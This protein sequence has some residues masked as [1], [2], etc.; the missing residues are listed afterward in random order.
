MPLYPPPSSGSGIPA[1]TVTTKGDLI[2]ATG[3]A[4]V[5]RQGVGADGTVLV[6]NSG[7][8][9]GVNWRALTAADVAAGT[10]P[11]VMVFTSNAQF[12]RAGANLDL[13]KFTNSTANK[14]LTVRTGTTDGIEFVNN[15]YTA[16]INT[17]ADSG[18]LGIVAS[19]VP[20]TFGSGAA[21]APYIQRGSGLEVRS[22]GVGSVTDLT[23]DTFYFNDNTRNFPMATFATTGLTFYAGNNYT[24]ILEV[25]TT[26]NEYGVFIRPADSP[27]TVPLIIRG[28]TS[29]AT[30]LFRI[31]NPG[32]TATL[33]AI[34]QDGDTTIGANLYLGTGGARVWS[35]N[36][37]GT[38]RLYAGASNSMILSSADIQIATN[39]IIWSNP[40]INALAPSGYIIDFTAAQLIDHSS[41]F[42]YRVRQKVDGT[43]LQETFS[44][45]PT[46]GVKVTQVSNANL[47]TYDIGVLVKAAA[48]QNTSTFEGQNSSGTPTFQVTPAGLVTAA[49]G[50]TSTANGTTTGFGYSTAQG[51]YADASNVAIRTTSTG[52]FIYFQAPSGATGQSAYY[53]PSTGELNFGYVTATAATTSTFGGGVTIAGALAGVTTLSTSGLITASAGLTIPTGQPLTV[54]SKKTFSGTLSLPATTGTATVLGQFASTAGAMALRI[55]LHLVIGSIQRTKTYEVVVDTATDSTNTYY[56]LLPAD[57]STAQSA[58]NDVALE[59]YRPSTATTTWQVWVRSS[60]TVFASTGALTWSAESYGDSVVTYAAALS[61]A[62]GASGGAV[63]TLHPSNAL[64]TVAGNVGIGTDIPSAMFD[65]RGTTSQTGDATIT[66][67]AAK[68]TFTDGTRTVAVGLAT[69]AN[70]ISANSVSGDLVVVSNGGRV[71][72]PSALA[73][74]GAT[75]SLSTANFTDLQVSGASIGR[76]YVNRVTPITAAQG[77]ITTTVDVTG[78]SITQTLVAGRR[79]RFVASGVGCF[80]TVAGDTYSI[81][82]LLGG[83]SYKVARGTC[84]ATTAQNSFTLISEVQ[85]VASGATAPQQINAGSTVCK[86]QIA[87]G[88]GTGTL[89]LSASATIPTEFS[90]EDIGS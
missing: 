24:S 14:S 13:I 64:D 83:V 66:K 44:V 43:N 55:H 36:N 81:T 48:S 10:F 37:D 53:K 39:S 62:T 35:P 51:F 19:Y 89:T 1:S 71:Y 65:V 54:G 76:G 84:T 11:G 31:R 38:L 26:N 90:I 12:S 41:S 29:H 40:S 77:S 21:N 72:I 30:D 87:R 79:Y 59:V 74:V 34:N 57:Q 32:N 86:L 27:S 4:A 80:S 9:T 69:A 8:S 67:N 61:P 50:F 42:A 28:A 70:D 58:G 20:L 82:L 17:F 15:A 78:G 7:Q 2:L 6:A 45:R 33:W 49:S 85:C 73:I 22:P 88:N 46:G 25:G 18:A 56:K 5:T 52:G 63:S 60:A 47:G 3:S 23:A 68:Q 75:T 16:V